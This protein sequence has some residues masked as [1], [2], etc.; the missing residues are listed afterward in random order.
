MNA[1]PMFPNGR[2][3]ILGVVNVTPDSFS[4]GGR[5]MGVGSEEV[6]VEAAVAAGRQLLDDGADWLDVGGEST[7]P[8]AEEVSLELEISRVVPVVEALVSGLGARVSVDTRKGRVAR[9]AIRA[10]AQA[11]NDVS[12]GAHDP[13]LLRAVAETPGTHLILG[14]LRGTPA[15]MQRAPRF[16]DLLGEVA[17]EL[18]ESLAAALRAGVSEECLAIDPGI[19]FGKGLAANLEL[20]AHAGWFRE[21]L[22]R[23]VLIGPSRKSFLGRITGDP[24]GSRDVATHAACAVAAFT[25][26]DG[27]R[28][29]EPGPVLRAVAVGRAVRDARRKELS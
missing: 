28:V 11:V 7:R 22:G 16:D 20:I 21:R 6:D 9:S 10:G 8:G 5:F 29:H 15:N 2:V 3:T 14:H 1:A 12:G 25:G 27:V 24:V 18:E 26:A 17:T 4:D 19:G 23:P 13:G